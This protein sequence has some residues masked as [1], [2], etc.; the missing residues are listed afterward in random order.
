VQA[1]PLLARQGTLWP[2]AGECRTG[3]EPWHFRKFPA[4]AEDKPYDLHQEQAR[5]AQ[6]CPQCGFHFPVMP[7]TFD[8]FAVF[9]DV[10]PPAPVRGQCPP[11]CR[12]LIALF[13][14]KRRFWRNIRL[15]SYLANPLSMSRH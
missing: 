12:R 11:K 3:S 8:S 13:A 7:E 5:L 9:K 14:S 4:Y 1:N 15:S 2:A 10:K 6:P